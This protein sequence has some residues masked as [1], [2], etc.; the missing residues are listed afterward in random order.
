MT[1]IPL[2]IMCH[3]SNFDKILDGNTK[4]CNRAVVQVPLNSLNIFGAKKCT[5]FLIVHVLF[6]DFTPVNI[7]YSTHHL[8]IYLLDRT[9]PRFHFGI[10]GGLVGPTLEEILPKSRH[11]PPKNG[12]SKICENPI[13]PNFIK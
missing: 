3:I 8:I 9:Y 4:I 11:N 5:Y 1:K 12:L 7:C 6:K 10:Q 13:R 2:T